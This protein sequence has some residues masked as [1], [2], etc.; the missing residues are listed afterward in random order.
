MIFFFFFLITRG[1]SGHFKRSHGSEDCLPFGKHS[2]VLKPTYSFV[3][4]T[5]YVIAR[6]NVDGPVQLLYR[7]RVAF[8]QHLESALTF[9]PKKGSTLYEFEFRKSYLVSSVREC[10]FS[11]KKLHAIN[12]IQQ[13]C[14]FD[15]FGMF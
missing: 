9:Q 14:L 6:D 13:L 2:R 7:V 8:D 5:L 1:C 11:Q 12:C 10:K 4:I 3:V 15:V